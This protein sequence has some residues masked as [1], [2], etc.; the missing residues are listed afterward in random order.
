[1]QNAPFQLSVWQ[2]TQVTLLYHF[3]SLEYLKGLQQRLHVLM[4][5]INPTLDLAKLQNRDALLTDQRWGTRNTSENWANN[6]WSFL[7]DFEL[8][9]TTAIAKR[10]F[11]VYSITAAN[12]CGRGLDELSLG[13]MTPDEQDEFEARFEQI[14]LY[15]GYIDDTMDQ[16]RTS[17]RWD[18]FNMTLA[19]QEF[20]DVLSR[21]PALRLRTDIT[22]QTGMVPVRTGVYLPVDDPHGTPQFCWTGNPAGGLLE[23][24]TFNSLGLE[25]L[26]AVGRQNLWIDDDSMHAFVQDHLRDPLLTRDTDFARSTAKPKLAPGLVACNAFTSRSCSWIYV[27]QIHGELESWAADDIGRGI[28]SGPRV[29]AGEMCVQPGYYFTPANAGSR[30]YFSTGEAMPR[31][32]GDYGVTIWQW[33]MNQD[34]R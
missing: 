33:D 32:D 22:G 14:S 8:S 1:M 25:A 5:S 29:E 11:E 18:D 16:S 9:V 7:A 17:G 4:A 6:G 21:A 20:P 23:C 13:W 34:S 3:A 31:T 19:R 28:E 30:R 26:A 2:K 27:E 12:Q 10:A 24:N 15:A